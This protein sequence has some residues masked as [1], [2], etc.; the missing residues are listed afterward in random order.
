MFWCK[1]SLDLQIKKEN[2]AKISIFIIIQYY[3]YID[4]VKNIN[5]VNLQRYKCQNFVH[6]CENNVHHV[7]IFYALLQFFS[8]LPTRILV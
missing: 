5:N 2:Y 3:E 4:L 6:V 7:H 8:T 1:Q